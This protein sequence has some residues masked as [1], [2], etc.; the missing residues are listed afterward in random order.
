MQCDYSGHMIATLRES[1]AKLS[2]LVERAAGGE[3]VIITVRGKP[4]AR[5]CPI[6]EASPDQ[7]QERE[8]WAKHLR[9]TRAAYSVGTHDSGSEILSEIRE[10]RS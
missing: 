10:D 3:E 2:A 1:K 5:L 4:K 8:K 9:E 7:P 6:I